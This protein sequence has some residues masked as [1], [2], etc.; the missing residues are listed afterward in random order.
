MNGN[1]DS[2]EVLA[3]TIHYNLISVR[4]YAIVFA[5]NIPLLGGGK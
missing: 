1:E 4:E 5:C 3:S 2:N